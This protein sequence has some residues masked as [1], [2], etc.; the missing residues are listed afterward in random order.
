MVVEDIKTKELIS[1]QR[2][3]GEK[4]WFL[5]VYVPNEGLKRSDLLAK[6]G[7]KIKQELEEKDELK[8]RDELIER[9]VDEFIE[10]G[11]GVDKLSKG[12]AGWV[13]FRVDEMGEQ[14]E[15]VVVQ[16]V[17][18][19]GVR[20]KPEEEIEVGK[21]LRLRQLFWLKMVEMEGL[22]LHLEREKAKLFRIKGDQMDLVEEKEN[23]FVYEKDK[24]Y[25][26]QLSPT[27]SEKHMYGSGDRSFENR[28][29][30]S[31]KRFVNRVDELLKREAD[32]QHNFV[33]ILYSDNF[34]DK[35]LK[36]QEEAEHKWSRHGVIVESKIFNKD[37]E[38]LKEAQRLIKKRQK[39][40]VKDKWEQVQESEKW[41]TGW[42]NVVQAAR[43]GK[44]EDLFITKDAE[45]DGYT[46]DSWLYTH[47]AEGAEKTEDLDSL[48]VIKVIRDGGQVWPAE[49]LGDEVEVG[50]RLRY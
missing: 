39:S 21:A 13:R 10:E 27:G 50:A 22:V 28:K 2:D 17:M 35:I 31:D 12:I 34:A 9:L 38:I 5:S 16:R 20:Q 40:L 49:V 32:S 48:L 45:R 25:L 4:V 43:E 15:K 42:K 11:E 14:S 37:N 29:E 8:D 23:P 19:G 36:W 1:W 6:T 7:L 30:E 47:A 46:D 26:E 18:V 41:V 44:V 33:V 24:E 3:V